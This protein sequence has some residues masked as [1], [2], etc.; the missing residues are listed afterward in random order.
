MKIS[1]ADKQPQEDLPFSEKKV[2]D[3]VKIAA[4]KK[5]LF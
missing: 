3:F 5:Q 4:F 1:F 2:G